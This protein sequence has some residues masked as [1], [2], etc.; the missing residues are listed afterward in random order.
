MRNPTRIILV[1]HGETDW[2][3]EQR[4]Q[5]WNDQ[6]LNARGLRQAKSFG[7][8]VRRR[9]RPENVWSSDLRRCMQTAEAIGL[10]VRAHPALRE[11]HLGEWE[12]RRWP[13][14]QLKWPNT[15]ARW[16]AG[17]P[18]CQA[19]GGEMRAGAA[20]RAEQFLAESR[21]LEARGDQVIVTHG[22]FLKGLMVALLALPD[23]AMIRFHMNNAA[24]AVLAPSDGVLQL[25]SLNDTSHLAR[26]MS[27]N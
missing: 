3:V 25:R 5:G 6:P 7:E 16:L 17:D 10:P 9:F 21:I 4:L 2:N 19:P 12:G 8:A 14:I 27:G 18:L 26:F 11:L 15:A 24:I 22:G 13:E 1:R 20:R 23:D